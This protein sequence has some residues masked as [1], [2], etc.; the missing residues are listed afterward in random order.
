MTVS[1]KQDTQIKQNKRV[2]LVFAKDSENTPSSWL[3][4]SLRQTRNE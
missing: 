1:R 4:F 3:Q 2:Q